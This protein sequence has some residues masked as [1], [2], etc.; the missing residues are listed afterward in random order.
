MDAIEKA[1]QITQLQGKISQKR[2]ELDNANSIA[3]PVILAIIGLLTLIW[4]VGILGSVEILIQNRVNLLTEK[5]KV[6]SF[7][8]FLCHISRK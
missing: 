2:F 1:K 7:L 5:S 4:I 6:Q 3:G 8:I